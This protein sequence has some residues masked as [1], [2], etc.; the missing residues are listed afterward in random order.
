MLH[1]PGLGKEAFV[2]PARW[3][4]TENSHGK[5]SFH[6]AVAFHLLP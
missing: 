2:S 5:Q 4:E 6:G 3:E 1:Q